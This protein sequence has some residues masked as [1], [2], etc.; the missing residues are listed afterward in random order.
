M[1]PRESAR[2]RITALMVFCLVFAAAVVGR[3]AYIQIAKNPRLEQMARRQFQSK[4]LIRPR[5]G[6]I[7]DRNGEPLAIN[8]EVSS[9]AANPMKIQNPKTLARLLSK[10]TDLPYAKLLARITEKREF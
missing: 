2:G 10:A 8:T 7:L 3:A 6:A 5:R 4:V 9:L 1:S